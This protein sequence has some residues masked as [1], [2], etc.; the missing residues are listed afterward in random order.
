MPWGVGLSSEKT[1]CLRTLADIM[2]ALDASIAQQKDSSPFSSK[3][4]FPEVGRGFCILLEDYI[5]IYT[6]VLG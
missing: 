1:K 3:E 2:T 5:G 4:A 6:A